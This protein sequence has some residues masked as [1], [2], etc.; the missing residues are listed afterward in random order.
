MN[1]PRAGRSS[2]EPKANGYFCVWQ[3]LGSDRPEQENYRLELWIKDRGPDAGGWEIHVLNKASQPSDDTGIAVA[4]D[5]FE[6]L[7]AGLRT[8]QQRRPEKAGT[9][10]VPDADAASISAALRERV[11]RV[12]KRLST[13]S[14]VDALRAPSEVEMFSIIAAAAAG[15]P[16]QEVE[17]KHELLG[18]AGD[19]TDDDG[20][21][22]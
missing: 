15:K 5:A 19:T 4:E 8:L 1:A 21:L 14:V 6:A 12:L 20:R 3:E 10:P 2:L 13:S 7:L 17:P 9:P 18:E 16:P 22:A 11:L